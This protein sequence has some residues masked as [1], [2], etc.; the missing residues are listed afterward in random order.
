PHFDACFYQ[1]A[2]RD[3]AQADILVVNHHLLFSDIAVRRVQENYT[4]PAVLPP[5]RRLVLDEAHN[6]EDAATEHLGASVSR[7]GLLRLL[8]RLD[9]RGKGLLSAVEARL[10]RADADLLRQDALHE[11]QA[12]VRPA[13]ERTRETGAEFFARLDTL[14]HGAGHDVL[15]LAGDFTGTSDWSEHVAP[16]L[17]DLLI[18]IERLAKGLVRLREVVHTDQRWAEA[19][20]EPLIELGGVQQRLL[21]TLD[22]LRL[23]GTGRDE[24]VSMVRWIERRGE[25]SRGNIALNAAPVDLAQLLRDSL[26]EPM[27]TVILTSAT[28]TTRDGFDFVR[29]RIGVAPG[30]RVQESVHPSPFEFETQTLVA[31]PTD[32]PAP[33]GESSPQFDGAVA[34][35]TEE[36]ARISDGGLFVLFTS[37]RSLRAVAGELRRRGADRRWPLFVQGEGPRA[38]LLERFSV[39]GRGV[40]LGVAS[41]WEGV[42]VPGDPLRGLIIAKLPFKVPTEPLTAARI[43]AIEAFGGNSFYEYMLP[44]AALRLKQG[45]GRL[46]RA[47]TD[48]G[49]V[50]ILD[51]RIHERGYGRYFLGS[52]PPAPV[53]V[54]TAAELLEELR[55][56]YTAPVFAVPQ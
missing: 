44:H 13:L 6:L 39:S 15:R 4:A 5:Y 42:D 36:L 9:R 37:Y 20:L 47:R 53:R 56:F 34:R 21:A 33:R 49:A 32:L 11:L 18:A 1:R 14:L 43:E 27:S 40:L 46:I 23:A 22:A 55:H 2:R 41:F 19:L 48:R 3:A 17:D 25:R 29:S 31:L 45:F 50:V 35:M 8:G 16:V 10:R 30:L 24:P 12:S 54:G 28:L 26:F 51:R 7:R 52:L 38:Q